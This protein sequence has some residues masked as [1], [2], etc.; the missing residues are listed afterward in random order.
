MTLVYACP[1]FYL[2]GIL[3]RKRSLSLWILVSLSSLHMTG[4]N[5]CKGG[6]KDLACP[7]VIQQHPE[8]FW[9]LQ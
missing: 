2:H 4:M 1:Y 3:D 9:R 8:G 7:M 5:L 6:F